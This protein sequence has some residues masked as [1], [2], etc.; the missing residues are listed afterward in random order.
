[1]KARQ[2]NS[3]DMAK[4]AQILTMKQL[5]LTIAEIKKKLVSLDTPDDIINALSEH[6]ASI[7]EKIDPC[8]TRSRL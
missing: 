3:K 4:L 7:R 2:A 1:M 6:A 5:G 8:Q